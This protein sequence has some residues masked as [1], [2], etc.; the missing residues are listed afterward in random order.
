MEIMVDLLG[1]GGTAAFVIAYYLVSCGKLSV[2]SVLYQVLNLGGAVAVGFSVF[3]R[4]AW[5]AFGLEILWGSIALVS[6]VR[7]LRRRGAA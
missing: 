2:D 7:I 3:P 4:K 5:P 1:W 6:L